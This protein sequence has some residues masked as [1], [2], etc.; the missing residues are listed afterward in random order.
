MADSIHHRDEHTRMNRRKQAPFQLTRQTTPRPAPT[1]GSSASVHRVRS[2]PR[3]GAHSA[4]PGHVQH[5]EETASAS[6]SRHQR[7]TNVRP[8]AATTGSKSAVRPSRP[9]A[10]ASVKHDRANQLYRHSDPLVSIG[11]E[12]FSQLSFGSDGLPA[13]FLPNVP[14]S[15][16]AVSRK[17]RAP[18]PHKPFQPSPG[19]AFK[20]KRIAELLTRPHHP[21]TQRM[22]RDIYRLDECQNTFLPPLEYPLTFSQ[23]EEF[24]EDP[25]I[26][27]E[28]EGKPKE[29]Q[30]IIP[31]PTTITVF[32]EDEH[33]EL[34]E[35]VQAWLDT[36]NSDVLFRVIRVIK[37][38][39]A[40][41]KLYRIPYLEMSGERV[42]E[43]AQK[44]EMVTPHKVLWC[45]LNCH[46]V[47]SIL[48]RPGARFKGQS[49]SDAAARVIQKNWRR[50]I[51]RKHELSVASQRYAAGVVSTIY[52]IRLH[53]RALHRRLMEKRDADFAKYHFSKTTLELIWDKICNIDTRCHLVHLPGFSLSKK[54]RQG[55]TMFPAIQSIQAP[56]VC[57]AALPNTQV[58][59]VS[60]EPWPQSMIDTYSV[61]IAQLAGISVQEASFRFNVVVAEQAP[62]FKKH[63]FSL[64]KLLDFSPRAM[65][66]LRESTSPES[67]DAAVI[68]PRVL[69]FETVEL[70]TRL[71]LPTMGPHPESANTTMH[72]VRLYKWLDYNQIPVPP[73]SVL[74]TEV[75]ET[76][77]H[78]MATCIAEHPHIRRW[79]LVSDDS[80]QTYGKYTFDVA[81]LESY[82]YLQQQSTYYSSRWVAGSS[83]MTKA[84]SRLHV[85]LLTKLPTLG[86][87]TH[88]DEAFMTWGE[89]LDHLAT[90]GGVLVA[91]VGSESDPSHV[92]TLVNLV[93]SGDGFVSVSS[94]W[95][96]LSVNVPAT[97]HVK[98]RRTPKHVR[99]DRRASVLAEQPVFGGKRRMSVSTDRYNTPELFD[100]PMQRSNVLS[101]PVWVSPTHTLTPDDLETV[102]DIAHEAGSACRDDGVIGYVTI[103]IQVLDFPSTS[104]ARAQ[105]RDGKRPGQDVE[106]FGNLRSR[107]ASFAQAAAEWD[108]THHSTGRRLSCVP[109]SRAQFAVADI[110][111]NISDAVVSAMPLIIRDSLS[112]KQGRRNPRRSTM[113]SSSTLSSTA[114]AVSPRLGSPQ[115]GIRPHS[116]TY[117]ARPCSPRSPH[118][119]RSM[120]PKP[121]ERRSSSF[122]SSPTRRR[123]SRVSNGSSAWTSPIAV[124]RRSSSLWTGV[125]EGKRGDPAN[126][127][128]STERRKSSRFSFGGGGGM[129]QRRFSQT[130][131][132]DVGTFDEND[133]A[134]LVAMRRLSATHPDV[135]PRIRSEE[136]LFYSPIQHSTSASGRLSLFTSMHGLEDLV[137]AGAEDMPG[138]QHGSVEASD[139]EGDDK[140]E[141]DGGE[142][143]DSVR[144][145]PTVET[146][147]HLTSPTPSRSRTT[148]PHHNYQQHQQQDKE[149]QFQSTNPLFRVRPPAETEGEHRLQA[150]L[151]SEPRPGHAVCQDRVVICTNRIQ[152]NRAAPF[153][154]A[155]L[156]ALLRAKKYEWEPEEPSSATLLPLDP[157]QN[158]ILGLLAHGES[159]QDAVEASRWLLMGTE[160]ELSAV[161][162]SNTKPANS[163]LLT[164]ID[165]IEELLV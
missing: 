66:E 86:C 28:E 29:Q 6:I 139:S 123:G 16:Q 53:H 158:Q 12:A 56:C 18:T 109:V 43:F 49:R 93:I 95:D 84:I 75:Y 34:P 37:N 13:L 58:T 2:V 132:E 39:H 54:C 131:F 10:S 127:L 143:E 133:Q 44:I 146:T 112:D 80:F 26:L 129:G 124:R 90:V 137:E 74:P 8:R 4:S 157:T 17:T 147:K 50:V 107:R 105:S 72:K 110:Q 97:L 36:L 148:S 134:D 23:D 155:T 89:F 165:K 159:L 145:F 114:P 135:E 9:P 64:G 111:T 144:D 151:L 98:S 152:D 68:I 154:F 122:A 19:E 52:I 78:A 116:P 153:D 40:L 14:P 60:A 83:L 31:V 63:S 149:Q 85:E 55:W 42:V 156:H 69:D 27:F 46:Q 102:L 115:D 38:A 128:S 47:Q 73:F 76:M 120:S 15:R 99:C 21:T 62:F 59:I 87:L 126:L 100:V 41:A 118:S 57:H 3:S 82:T 67:T 61:M 104:H 91:S 113:F 136:E 51:R 140:P 96:Q 141:K 142:D 32:D 108:S 164:L 101:T 11:Q 81:L 103:T 121:H 48:A 150:I 70:S 161:D 125:V 160:E 22:L 45:C 25:E 92:D 33:H 88:Y 117:G 119:P 35:E 162:I 20:Q 130:I 5:S 1:P 77:G 24:D 30:E 138:S 163:P 71:S 94:V 7:V 65:A 79:A 106:S